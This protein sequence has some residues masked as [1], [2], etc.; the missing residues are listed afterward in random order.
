V[1]RVVYSAAA[2]RDLERTVDFLL[3]ASP[4]SVEQA[5]GQITMRWGFSR[6]IPALDAA[7]KDRC[8]SS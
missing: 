1:A 2:L 5:V 8:A 3:E 4:E 7:F 6:G